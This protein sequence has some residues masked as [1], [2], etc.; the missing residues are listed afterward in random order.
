MGWSWRVEKDVK[1]QGGDLV[2]AYLA[3]WYVRYRADLRILNTHNQDVILGDGNAPV[4][5]GRRCRSFGEIKSSE[6]I[7]LKPVHVGF[8]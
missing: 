6:V 3:D 7:R 5:E 8:C 2:R 4:P 1:A